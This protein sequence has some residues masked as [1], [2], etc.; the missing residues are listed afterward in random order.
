MK[1][2]SYILTKSRIASFAVTGFAIAI[3]LTAF[4]AQADEWNKKTILTIDQPMQ[5][6]DTYLEPGKYVF[7]LLDSQSDRHIVQIFNADQTH[8]ITTILAIPDY[9][10]QPTGRSQFQFWETPAGFVGALKAWYYPGDN[11][12]QEFPYPEHLR[13]VAIAQTH[14]ETNAVTPP[15]P[16]SEPQQQP[17]GC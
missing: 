10:V 4:R 6:M 13:R 8:L 14:T 11:F 1:P 2:K 12:G 15:P 9:R 7:K 3:S 16:A 5:V 17:G